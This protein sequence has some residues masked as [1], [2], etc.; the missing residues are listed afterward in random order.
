MD[1]ERL[2]REEQ[3]N[4]SHAKARDRKRAAGRKMP[5]H[6][7]SVFVLQAA[8]A[9]RADRKNPHPSMNVKLSRTTK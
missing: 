9:K 1:N 5:V 8:L 4:D 7:R 2:D 6:G 3:E